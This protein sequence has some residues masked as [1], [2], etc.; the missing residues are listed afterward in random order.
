MYCDRK[1]DTVKIA[2][3]VLISFIITF[4]SSFDASAQKDTTKVDSIDW[5]NNQLLITYAKTQISDYKYHIYTND[6]A[7]KV[8]NLHHN[9]SR[10]IF[11]LVVVIVLT[12]LVF[13]G[14]QFFITLK[15]FSKKMA[16][17]GALPVQGALATREKK[18]TEDGGG[19]EPPIEEEST[20]TTVKFGKDGIEVSSSILGVIILAMSLV[21]FY[22]YLHFVYP[23]VEVT[24]NTPTEQTS[25]KK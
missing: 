11:F 1:I 19:E 14:V 4:G 15:S 3:A 13:S 18:K 8:Y 21:F 12:G 7:I 16:H 5:Y 22:M 2:A 9:L 24:K 10:Y 20:R 17:T 6:H 25:A 23:V